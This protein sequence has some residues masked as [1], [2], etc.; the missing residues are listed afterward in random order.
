MRDITFKMFFFLLSSHWCNAFDKLAFSKLSSAKQGGEV[1]RCPSASEKRV[2][3]HLREKNILR[4][5][6][7]KW[8]T[9]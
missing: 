7:L 2:Y 5:F 3:V 6:P 8:L 4:R 9:E 1:M